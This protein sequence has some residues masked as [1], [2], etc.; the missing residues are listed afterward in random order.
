MTKTKIKLTR[1]QVD[2]I[3]KHL[4]YP[5]ND[6]AGLLN[7]HAEVSFWVGEFESLGHLSQADMARALLIG[8]EVEPKFKEDDW[9]VDEEIKKIYQLK[10]G[11]AQMLSENGTNYRHVR[12]ATPEEIAKEKE[13]RWWESNG[14]EV[15]ELKQGDVLMGTRRRLFRGSDATMAMFQTKTDIRK[16]QVTG[17]PTVD[18]EAWLK[19]ASLKEG[20]EHSHD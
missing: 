4:G 13:R 20:H 3:E 12:L 19:G 2:A 5:D 6:V 7:L 16:N 18:F 1:E 10:V 11:E 9:V 14:R 17:I 15:W 8:Y